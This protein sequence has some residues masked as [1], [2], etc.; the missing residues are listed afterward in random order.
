MHAKT[1]IYSVDRQFILFVRWAMD[2]YFEGTIDMELC[3]QGM[4][5]ILE[6]TANI[7]D[8]SEQYSENKLIFRELKQTL[9]GKN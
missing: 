5:P 4:G 8:Q 6:N 2:S 9:K 7:K 3:P 1:M